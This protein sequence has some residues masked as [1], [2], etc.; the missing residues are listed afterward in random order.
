MPWPQRTWSSWRIFAHCRSI[1][2]RRA[3]V[4]EVCASRPAPPPPPR[5][6]LATGPSGPLARPP[7]DPSWASR[8][9]Q[10]AA[11]VKIGPARHRAALRSTTRFEPYPTVADGRPIRRALGVATET[12]L[13]PPTHQ[14][15]GPQERRRRIG[16]RRS[17][18]RNVLALG[19]GRRRVRPRTRPT[20]GRGPVSGVARNRR[21]CSPTVAEAYAACDAVLLP[22]LWEGFGNPS[23]ESATYRRPLAIGPYPVASGTGGVRV[24]VVRHCPAGV[25]GRHGCD[26]PDDDLLAHNHQIAAQ[27]FTRWRTCRPVSARSS[28]DSEWRSPEAALDASPPGQ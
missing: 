13:A 3:L 28:K 16:G 7:D 14:G 8:D 6:A 24:P 10:R 19:T 22:S 2:R 23:V 1:R 15:P 4:A 17:A 9:H 25:P 26:H 21:R 27:H 5:P 12:R 11:A 20:G 18:R